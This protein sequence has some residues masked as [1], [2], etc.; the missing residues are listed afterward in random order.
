MCLKKGINPCFQASAPA[1]VCLLWMLLVVVML[2]L[3][4]FYPRWL[5]LLNI[6]SFS[7]SG[8]GLH[9]WETK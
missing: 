3:C 1:E 8:E 6:C 9:S 2:C 5:G 7:C 4:L